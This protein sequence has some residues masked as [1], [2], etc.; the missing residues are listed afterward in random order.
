MKIALVT[1]FFF[2]SIFN[3]ALAEKPLVYF[4]TPSKNEVFNTRDGIAI[5]V[6]T[7][8]APINSSIALYIHPNIPVR[9][10]DMQKIPFGPLTGNSLDLPNDGSLNFYWNSKSLGCSQDGKLSSCPHSFPDG[11]YRF[12]V[13]LIA[14]KDVNLTSSIE[15]V[16]AISIVRNVSTVFQ[17]EDEE[18]LSK[19]E[20]KLKEN[21]AEHLAKL[22]GLERTPGPDLTDYLYSDGKLTEVDENSYRCQSYGAV[23]PFAGTIKACLQTNLNPMVKLSG[24][25]ELQL[26]NLSYL[27]AREKA[28]ILSRKNY[29]NRVD[30]KSKDELYKIKDKN[31]LEIATYIESSVTKWGYNPDGNHWVFII[32]H[33]KKSRRQK[34][35]DPFSVDLVVVI[36]QNGWSC[37]S[38]VMTHE[39]ALKTVLNSHI[40][41]CKVSL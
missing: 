3:Y 35:S 17:L 10:M 30:F 37:L 29:E 28:I 8:D 2:I 1:T 25:I 32:N 14:K 40:D 21:A 16:E 9:E 34:F 15:D 38:K 19:F 22:S 39:S 27:E 11:D 36:G 26:G 7:K 20:K 41:Y 31:T 18:N 6:S 12:K 5:K 24:K 4:E 33:L 23:K 13:F